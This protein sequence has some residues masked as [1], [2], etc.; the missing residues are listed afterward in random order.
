MDP[1]APGPAHVTHRRVVLHPGRHP[2]RARSR[3]AA[4]LVAAVTPVALF[5]GLRS[6]VLGSRETPPPATWQGSA[7]GGDSGSVNPWAVGDAA[8]ARYL[9]ARGGECTAPAP[10]Q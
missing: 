6:D 9:A 3:R 1:Q 10:P 4:L 8:V 7:A 2:A 5:V